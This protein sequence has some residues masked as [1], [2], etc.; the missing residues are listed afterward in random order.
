MPQLAPGVA[1]TLLRIMQEALTNV[2]RHAKA[3]QVYV[4]VRLV[5]N[6]IHLIVQDDGIGIG[7]VQ[8]KGYL[9]SHGLKIMRERVEAFGGSLNLGPAP[10]KG[11]RIEA[12]IPIQ[13][14]TAATE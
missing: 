8:K 5:D 13:G 14:N 1:M 11:T 3:N 12:S 6:M 10:G 4:S 9:N 7:D 2:A